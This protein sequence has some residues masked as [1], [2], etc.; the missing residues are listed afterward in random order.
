MFP[1]KDNVPR[2]SPPVMTYCLILANVLVFGFELLLSD[3]ALERLFYHFGLVPYRYT[4]PAWAE[5]LGYPD[6]YWP[7]ITNMFLHGGWLH[8]I[9]NMWTL[10][11]FGDNVEDC[12]GSVRFTVFYFLC[13]VSASAVHWVTNPEST[14]PALGASGAIAGVLAA[15]F[16]LFPL[17]RII[18]L[19]PIFFYPFFV[20]IPAFFYLVFWFFMQFLSG[21]LSLVAPQ[22]GGGIAWWAHIGG[23]GA[24][25]ILVRLFL[26]PRGQRRCLQNDEYGWESAWHA[27]RLR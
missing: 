10:W 17:A 23:F 19:I 6:N 15:Y 2:R 24:G 9:S 18:T 21:T 12:M 26:L 25:I 7:F 4:H 1:I 22:Q 3:R 14:V 20:E 11:I 8:V 27:R 13:G 16:V 5:S